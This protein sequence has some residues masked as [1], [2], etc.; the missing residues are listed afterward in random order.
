ML[1]RVDYD[2]SILVGENASGFTS[3]FAAPEI[4][5]FHIR[6]ADGYFIGASAEDK[7]INV[8]Q[9]DLFGLGKV[10]QSMQKGVGLTPQAYPRAP[11]S[12][13]GCSEDSVEDISEF[14]PCQKARN[15]AYR[16]QLLNRLFTIVLVT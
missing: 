12:E 3:A 10:A 15:L 14:I 1:V 7:V 16:K 2:N 9:A 8:K 4:L 11:Y 6:D 13:S 5:T